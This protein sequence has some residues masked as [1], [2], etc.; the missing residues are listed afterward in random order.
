MK[1]EVNLC[2]IKSSNNDSFFDEDVK[3]LQ[4]KSEVGNYSYFTH[5]T[6][7]ISIFQKYLNPEHG[8]FF[9]SNDFPLWS[10]YVVHWSNLISSQFRLDSE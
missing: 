9:C 6:L 5:L 8:K 1:E 2:F 4:C 7:N 3:L 10:I